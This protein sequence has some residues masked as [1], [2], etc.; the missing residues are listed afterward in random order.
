MDKRCRL[1]SNPIV[2]K[3][4]TATTAMAAKPAPVAP[5]FRGILA[6]T[7]F[8][9]LSIDL[10]YP[11][12]FGRCFLSPQRKD[13]EVT[14]VGSTL[15]KGPQTPTKRTIAPLQHTFFRIS[16]CCCSLFHFKVTSFRNRLEACVCKITVSG[17][18]SIRSKILV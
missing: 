16:V 6:R 1:E 8:P 4:Q 14:Q 2:S 12:R 11:V 10:C 9:S 18:S 7:R 3:I 5:E 15:K 17:Q 13:L